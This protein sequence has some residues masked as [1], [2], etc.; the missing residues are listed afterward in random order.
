MNAV[1][2][3]LSVVMGICANRMYRKRVVTIVKTVDEKLKDGADFVTVNP[4]FMG[5]ETYLSK[6]NLRKMFLAKQGGVSWAMPILVYGAMI[7]LTLL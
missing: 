4:M 5:Q 2:L 7:M 1:S 3:L 6:E